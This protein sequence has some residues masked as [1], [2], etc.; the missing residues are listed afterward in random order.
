MAGIIAAATNNAKG[1]AG[2]AYDA[3][4][5]PVRV[6]GRCGEHESD[7]IDGI[8]WAAGG[9]VDGV[10][11]NQHPAEVLSVSLGDPGRCSA[12]MQTAINS[13]VGR[14]ATVVVAAGNNNINVAGY[15]PASCDNVIA[16]AA[17]DRNGERWFQ[18][19]FGTLVDIAAPGA[20]IPLLSDVGQR[21]PRGETYLQGQSGTSIS[22]AVVSGVVAQVQSALIRPLT[23]AQMEKLLKDTATPLPVTPFKPIGAG[24]VNAA[25]ALETAIGNE[26]AALAVLA[27][28]L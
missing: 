27:A 4:I 7:I 19:N 13:A 9:S 21:G 15:A 28:I 26:R 1:T 20:D 17:T 8:V 25:K 16:V 3:K 22:T 6:S 10:P 11:A 24:I 5:V 2:V 18:S 23:P 14:G 12:A